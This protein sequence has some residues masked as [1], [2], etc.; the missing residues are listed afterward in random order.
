MVTDSWEHHSVNC[1]VRKVKVFTRKYKLVCQHAA[2]KF[3]IGDMGNHSSKINRK[4]VLDP[5]HPE[6]L[7]PVCVQGMLGQLDVGKERTDL[8]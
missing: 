3:E 6:V 4:D 5:Q 2:R 8:V 7:P 1:P